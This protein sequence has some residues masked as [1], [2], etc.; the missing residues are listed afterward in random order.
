MVEQKNIE[1]RPL[2]PCK[3]CRGVSF[4]MKVNI[5]KL[6]IRNTSTVKIVPEEKKHNI[7]QHFSGILPKLAKARTVLSRRMS[8]TRRLSGAYQ[9]MS[10]SRPISYD[11]SFGQLPVDDDEID[12]DDS[13]RGTA[14]NNLFSKANEESD[15][16]AKPATV[17]HPPREARSRLNT[18]LLGQSWFS[19][20]KRLFA[21]SLLIN[22]AFLILAITGQFNYAKSQAALFSVA[23]ILM[24]V[25]IRNEVFLYIVFWLTLKIF[26]HSWIPQ[27]FKNYV[28]AFLQSLGGIH[29]GC[30]VS[31]VMW[32]TYAIEQVL[33]HRQFTSDEILGVA[34]AI[35]VLLVFSCLGAF[36]LI[37]HLHHNFFE[38]VHRFS[39]WS[40]LALVWVFIFLSASYDPLAKSY[41]VRASRLV[42]RQELWYAAV[43]TFMIIL[44]WLTVRRT[45]VETVI[46]QARNNSLLNFSGGMKPGILARISRSPLKEWHAFGIIS[47]GKKRHTILAGAVGDFTKGLVE[48]PPSHIWVRSFHFAGAPYLVNMYERAVLVATGSGIG[49]YM[50]FLLQQ[51]RADCHVIWIAK[52]IRKSYGD[53]IF[54]VVSDT[55]PYR[56]TVVD[57]AVSGRAKTTEIVINK[58]REW[59]AQVV[60][61]TSNPSGTKQIVGACRKAGIA[62]YGPIW[63]S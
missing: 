42:K 56:C 11:H 49:V 58:A 18:I 16:P 29:S 15:P 26:G 50:S 21:V 53:E 33:T 28:T 41:S 46:P 55:P 7:I 4:E 39:G 52:S 38:G 60:V 8:W 30:G 61:V 27:L 25:L 54:Q 19:L 23:N 20:Y 32:V 47:D 13:A 37:R 12:E 5:D 2:F 3:S 63:D 22:L 1:T 36:P 59:G 17:R 57:T 31:S 48:D 24:A 43:T 40:S 35:L 10:R 62:A 34:I 6:L 45:H 9:T 14:E 44:P 51:T